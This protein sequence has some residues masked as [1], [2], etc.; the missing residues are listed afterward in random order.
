MKT[1]EEL[2]PDSYFEHFLTMFNDELNPES[3]RNHAILAK[4]V[5]GEEYLFELKKELDLIEKNKDWIFFVHLA[6]KLEL[7]NV[8]ESVLLEMKKEIDK[9]LKSNS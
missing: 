3:Y 4:N 9:I 6:E 8:T 5:E 2:Y 7:E 1:L